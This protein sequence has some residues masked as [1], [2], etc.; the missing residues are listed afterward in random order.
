MATA[1]AADGAALPEPAANA[2]AAAPPKVTPASWNPELD[3]KFVGVWGEEFVRIKQGNFKPHN[4]GFVAE[5]INKELLDSVTPFTIKQCQE[6]I[7]SLK[8]RF[9]AN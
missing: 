3:Q 4:W 8:K 7:N 9:A 5:Q 2:A 6:K 1:D